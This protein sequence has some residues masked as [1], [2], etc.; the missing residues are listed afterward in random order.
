MT[1]R[2]PYEV[3]GVER[4]ATQDDV[5]KAYRRLAFDCHP[6]RNPGDRTA[7][8]KFKEI[9]LAYEV[10]NDPESRARYDRWGTAD[11][12][13]DLSDMFGGF[14]LDDA[15]RA[16]MENFG[17]GGFS[18]G[19]R[20]R[21]GADIEAGVDL[22]LAEAAFGATREIRVKRAEP[23]PDCSGSGADSAAGWKTCGSCG[24]QGRIRASRRTILGSISTVETCADCS[25]AG[26]KAGARCRACNGA[27]SKTFDRSIS[28]DIPA[29]ITEGHVLKLRGHGHQPGEALAGDLSIR[30]RKVDYGP[31]KRDGA[32]L[33]YGVSISIP[34]AALGSRIS[35]PVIGGER[36]VE[37]P[38]GT[39]PGDVIV[40]RNEGMGRLGGRGRGDLRVHVNVYIP[41]K[42]SG[43]EKRILADLASSR[44]FRRD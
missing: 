26:R 21:K 35:V 7:E 28:V 16:F 41:R 24:G 25:G 30:I 43:A 40:L 33:V 8:E 12:A 17:F 9:T 36:E 29:G 37:I 22:E 27:G 15:I 2:D 23:C 10:L 34:D 13:P 6:D 38:P 18:A 42:L 11:G 4:D 32:D 19:A 14:G 44:N 31:L 20:S 5:K 3:L 1:G 39:Q